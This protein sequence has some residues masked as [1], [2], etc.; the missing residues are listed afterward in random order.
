MTI[1]G[2]STKD[3][4][5]L[6]PSSFGATF[7]VSVSRAYGSVH[8]RAEP[9]GGRGTSGQRAAMTLRAKVQ[10]D[11]LIRLLSPNWMEK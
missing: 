7:H 10:N 4:R 11:D 9:V 3:L 1:N 2:V 5:L 6:A 8:V